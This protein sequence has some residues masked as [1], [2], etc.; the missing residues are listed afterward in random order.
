GSA[1]VPLT[2]RRPAETIALPR[3]VAAKQVGRPAMPVLERPQLRPYLLPVHDAGDA[4]HVYLVDQLSL[5]PDAVALP[6][7][8]F[9]ALPLFDGNRTLRDVQA[10]LA[11]RDGGEVVPLQ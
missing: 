1:L 7:R 4:R 9:P 2:A 3:T 10:E 11:R 8:D 5:L 6:R